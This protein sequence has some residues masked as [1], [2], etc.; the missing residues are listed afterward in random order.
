MGYYVKNI[1]T[2]MSTYNLEPSG[3]IILA[4]GQVSDE[5]NTTQFNGREIQ[6]GLTQ[7]LLAD[8]TA[9]YGGGPTPPPVPPVPPQD[10]PSLA[11][12]VSVTANVQKVVDA[13]LITQFSMVEWMYHALESGGTNMYGA[14]MQAAH[15]GVT[16]DFTEFSVLTV[17]TSVS[18]VVDVDI[19]DGKMRLLV[20]APWNGTVRVLRTAI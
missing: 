18:V 8:V 17:G 4:P 1:T 16:V 19:S 13:V 11:K 3:N 2:G 15:N 7:R 10:P 14:E 6:Q 12:A 5:L 20:T 9:Q